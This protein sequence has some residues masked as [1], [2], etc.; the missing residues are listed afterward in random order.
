MYMINIGLV[1]GTEFSHLIESDYL[2]SQKNKYFFQV[3]V[4]M[5][6]III[7]RYK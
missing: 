6:D 7:F 1:L 3:T 4:T 2:I 5:H